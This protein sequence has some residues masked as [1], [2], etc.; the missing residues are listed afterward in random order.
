MPTYYKT[1]EELRPELEAIRD[2]IDEAL[3]AFQPSFSRA[4][5]AGTLR[6]D[7]ARIKTSLKELQSLW[8][9]REMNQYWIAIWTLVKKI[10]TK[11]IILSEENAERALNEITAIMLRNPWFFQNIHVKEYL[12]NAGV[13]ASKIMKKISTALVDSWENPEDLTHV[14][15]FYI[16]TWISNTIGKEKSAWFAIEDVEWSNM[17]TCSYMDIRESIARQPFNLPTAITPM[18]RLALYYIVPESKDILQQIIPK[19]VGFMDH[20]IFKQ[21]DVAREI[22]DLGFLPA[23]ISAKDVPEAARR[24]AKMTDPYLKKVIGSAMIRGLLRRWIEADPDPVSILKL[25]QVRVEDLGST[26]EDEV[27]S[28]R[29]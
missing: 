9:G 15:F 10:I 24:R 6:T 29:D 19:L 20:D 13:Q 27:L 17:V 25:T 16:L 14:E 2:S 4:K 22:Y 26:L 8:N 18:D 1:S 12:A 11:K 3:R 7:A 28:L 5:T 21:E 23:P